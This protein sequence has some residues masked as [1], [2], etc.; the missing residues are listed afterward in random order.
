MPDRRQR[1]GEAYG[2]EHLAEEAL[3]NSRR[4]SLLVLLVIL[5]LAPAALSGF[6]GIGPVEVTIWLVLLAAWVVAFVVWARSPRDR[7]QP[8]GRASG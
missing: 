2:R 8:S 1:V 7:A 6:G 3:V 5:L 4:R